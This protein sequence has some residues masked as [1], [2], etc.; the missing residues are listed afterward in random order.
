MS[1]KYHDAIVGFTR[2]ASGA[3]EEW[4]FTSA[5]P[6]IGIRRST[7]L[8]GYNLDASQFTSDG[9]LLQDSNDYIL[10][11]SL[12]RAR[13]VIEVDVQSMSL[14]ILSG[15]HQRFIMADDDEGFI[16]RYNSHQ[17]EFYGTSGWAA[18]SGEGDPSFFSGAT[19]RCEIDANNYWHIYRN[20]VLW[21]EPNVPSSLRSFR[22]G[23]DA[24]SLRNATIAG[25]RFL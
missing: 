6:L 20:G 17:W 10:L 16:Y 19:V 12:P 25:M 23:S 24:N 21:Y 18:S 8:S 13:Y 2:G 4:D 11:G 15:N 3:I 5:T 14:P 1:I 22:L 7:V 9:I